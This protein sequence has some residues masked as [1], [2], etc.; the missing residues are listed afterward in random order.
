MLVYRIM[1]IHLPTE[2]RVLPGEVLYTRRATCVQGRHEIYSSSDVDGKGLARAGD[3]C[4]AHITADDEQPHADS[5]IYHILA[6]RIGV[7]RWSSDNTQVTVE[8]PC[9]RIEST[10]IA[11]SSSSSSSTST[12]VFGPR[13]GDSV[14]IRIVRVSRL[15]AM[16]E[17]I[18]INGVWSSSS[19]G[20]GASSASLAFRGVLR[21]EDIRPFRPNAASSSS[22]TS[23]TVT[24]PTPSQSFCSGDVVLA[25]V[26]SQSD[27]R[28]YQLS[29]LSARC[30]V[31]EA[32]ATPAHYG[33]CHARRQVTRP[34]T[35]EGSVA[36]AM[37]CRLVCIPHRRDVML[38]PCD[39]STVPRWA[40]LTTA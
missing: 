20:G 21:T 38:N 27:A 16:G 36:P 6:S 26:I 23:A 29:T 15:F 28:Q 2:S 7:V 14:H 8:A 40:P 37:R 18:A 9:N 17:I 22:S 32:Y 19:S 3:G 39:G 34:G 33:S 24:A 13:A 25:E 10:A 4:Y 11:A 30:G 35:D 1:S 12:N 5:I 31:V